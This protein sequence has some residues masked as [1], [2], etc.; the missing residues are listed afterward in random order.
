MKKF[1]DLIKNPVFMNTLT[2]K[3]TPFN[4]RYNE[5]SEKMVQAYRESGRV[6][7]RNKYCSKEER[8]LR[9]KYK[10]LRKIKN[11]TKNNTNIHNEIEQV[12]EEIIAAEGRRINNTVTV[13]TGEYSS[14]NEKEKWSH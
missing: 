12:K 7:K 4:E 3:M 13:T 8:V 10:E 2:D 1:R 14:D 9:K 11:N 6:I 5:W